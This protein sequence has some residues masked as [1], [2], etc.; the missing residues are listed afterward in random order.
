MPT[1]ALQ[2][3]SQIYEVAHVLWIDLNGSQIA[4]CGFLVVLGHLLSHAKVEPGVL[5]FRV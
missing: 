4:D 5:C 2:R 3:A 1:Y